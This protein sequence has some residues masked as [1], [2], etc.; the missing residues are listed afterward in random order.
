MFLWT[1]VCLRVPSI[2]AVSILGWFP[3]S[4]QYMVLK[5]KT[6]LEHTT[7]KHNRAYMT[8]RAQH[9]FLPSLWIQCD[10][11]GLVNHARDEGLAMLA[12]HL[13]HF[14]N[15]STRVGPV[16]VSSHPVHRYTPRHLQ[17]FDLDMRTEEFTWRSCAC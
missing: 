16:Q 13:S 14:N 17:L 3:Q 1:R 5:G 9:S 6:E 4:A 11:V 2:A 7:R 8:Q 10:G 15:I 12:G